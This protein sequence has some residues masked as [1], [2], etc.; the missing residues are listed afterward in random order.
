[1]KTFACS[2]RND[3]KQKLL[4]QKVKQDCMTILGDSQLVRYRKGVNRNASINKFLIIE[5]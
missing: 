3:V 1:M 5:L 2:F 4:D